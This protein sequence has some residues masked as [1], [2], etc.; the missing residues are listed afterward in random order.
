MSVRDNMMN[1]PPISSVACISAWEYSKLNIES[2][3]RF[4]SLFG[5]FNAPIFIV[6]TLT[7]KIQYYNKLSELRVSDPTGVFNIYLRQLDADILD[8]ISQ[9]DIPG[10]ISVTGTIIPI[11]GSKQSHIGINAELV[12]E[13]TRN[14]RNSWMKTVINNAVTRI[15]NVPDSDIRTEFIT[16]LNKLIEIVDV[17]D[18]TTGSSSSTTGLSDEQIFDIITELSGKKGAPI[19]EVILKLK[20]SGMTESDAKSVLMRLIESGDCYMPLVDTIKIA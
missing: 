2:P 1:T 6:G 17:D 10:F 9:I 19:S 14:I 8:H 16:Y 3:T 4:R 11:Y 12:L 18:T 7:E 5:L 20:S 13:S 15:E